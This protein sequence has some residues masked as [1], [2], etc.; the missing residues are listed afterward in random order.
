MMDT[1]RNQR[2]EAATNTAR[3]Q[4]VAQVNAAVSIA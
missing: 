3:A 2:G 4:A 1:S